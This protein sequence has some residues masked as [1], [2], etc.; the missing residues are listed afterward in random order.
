MVNF[1]T[2]QRLFQYLTYF[3]QDRELEFKKA[4]DSTLYNLQFH[5]NNDSIYQHNI[6]TRLQK[7][8][9]NFPLQTCLLG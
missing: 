9:K 4:F 5:L 8:F 2:F 3:Y 6:G 1:N 7:G